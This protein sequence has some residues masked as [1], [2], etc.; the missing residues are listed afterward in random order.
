M[1][2]G[3]AAEHAAGL[4]SPDPTGVS[5]GVAADGGSSAAEPASD[6][7]EE[8][9]RYALNGEP[10]TCEESKRYYG[11]QWTDMWSTARGAGAAG[12]SEEAVGSLQGARIAD[13][14][15][16][17]GVHE[18]PVLLSLAELRALGQEPKPM[19]LQSDARAAL[20]SAIQVLSRHAG[21]GAAPPYDLCAVWQGWQRYFAWHDQG[22]RIVGTGVVQLQEEQILGVTDPNRF[23]QLRVDIVVHNVD[24][25]Y[26]RLHPGSQ[27]RRD[28]IP[29]RFTIGATE[30][31]ARAPQRA[32]QMYQA[33]RGD[34][35]LASATAIPQYDRFGR[36][37]FLE[38]L[39]RAQ[40]QIPCDVTESA[41]VP[42]RRWFCNL[43]R[44]SGAVIGHGIRCVRLEALEAE[45]AAPGGGASQRLCNVSRRDGRQVQMAS[46]HL[47]MASMGG[48]HAAAEI[49]PFGR[50]E[51]RLRKR[52]RRS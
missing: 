28:A 19:P 45:E 5:T 51:R 42:W 22:E 12:P 2:T 39:A 49:W 24:G 47:P 36:E 9:R 37:E 38:I 16:P 44:H 29:Q 6:G 3:V 8:E 14:G 31:D 43:G 34:F 26:W 18:P 40:V 46:V 10:Y 50:E 23:G 13:G 33:P 7:Q 15:A 48:W 35:D 52:R 11:A 1:S 25:G 20:E 21:E 30:P 17:G 27:K 32:A 4:S 41:D